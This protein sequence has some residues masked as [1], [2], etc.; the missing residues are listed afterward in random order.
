MDRGAW[1]ATGPWGCKESDMTKHACFFLGSSCEEF[2][3][4]GIRVSE[5]FLRNS[6]SHTLVPCTQITGKIY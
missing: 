4:L 1:Q 3:L 5:V 2:W 6:G